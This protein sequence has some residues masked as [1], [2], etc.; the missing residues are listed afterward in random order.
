MYTKD[1]AGG[2]RMLCPECFAEMTVV[3]NGDGD[4]VWICRCKTVLEYEPDD[5][6]GNDDG[7][8]EMKIRE[9]GGNR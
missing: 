4:P 9:N 5:E 3:D 2:D 7:H 1:G 8:E 6:G